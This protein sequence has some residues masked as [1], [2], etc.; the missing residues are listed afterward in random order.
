M[1]LPNGFTPE[2]YMTTGK[3]ICFFVFT[4]A[5]VSNIGELWNYMSALCRRVFDRRGRSDLKK[6]PEDEDDDDPNTRIKVQHEL[7]ALY[8][9]PAFRGERAYSRMMSTLFVI[10]MYSSGMPLLYAIGIVFYTVTYLLH[11]LL[12]IKF[13]KKSTTSTRTIPMAAVQFLKIGLICH[14]ICAAFMLTNPTIFEVREDMSNPHIAF[15]PKTYVEDYE[16]QAKDKNSAF[17]KFFRR[18]ENTH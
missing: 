9:G 10:M 6:D 15:S 4:S 1:Q 14:M 5:F 13:F 18:I 12:I 7:E 3:A 17:S 2:W 11:K 8:T 16:S